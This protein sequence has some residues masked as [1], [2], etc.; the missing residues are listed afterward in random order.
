[1]SLELSLRVAD[2]AALDTPLLIV[3]VPVGDA[4]PD[5]LRAFDG[6]AGGT[7]AA[8]WAST[9]F[10]GKRDETLVCYPKGSVRR[11]LLVGIGDATKV[12]AAALRRAAMI[13]GK[14]ARTLGVERAALAIPATTVAADRAVQALAEGAAFGA[15]HYTELKMPADPPKPPVAAIELIATAADPGHDAGLARGRAIAAGQAFARGLQVLPAD[16]C[17]PIF[18]AERAKELAARHGMKLT[19]LDQ[20][21]LEKEGMHALLAVAK[22]SVNEPRFIALEY[23]GAEGA[24]V[25]L[26]GKGVTFDAGGISIKPAQGME[27]MKYDMSGAAGVLGTM[28][29]LGQLKP[30]LH[31]VGLVPSAENMVSGSAYRPGDVVRSHHGKTIEVLNTDAE[32][33]LLLADSLSWARRYNPAAVVDCATL[34]GA[35]VIG[36]GHTASAVMGTDPELVAQLIAAGQASGE[37][38]WELPLWDEYRDLIK[39]DIADVKN[40]GGR[41]AGSITAGWFLREFV[42]G[43]PWAH[44]DIAGTAYTDRESAMHGKGPMGVPV[45]LFSEFLLARL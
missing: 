20:A 5:S 17:T 19:V 13:G 15:W 11:L 24:P 26:V 45:R 12:D 2:P 8:A 43:Y 3:P 29:M 37:R 32:G 4:V 27:E 30:K 38:C 14:R 44:L 33:R 23:E 6:S 42:E 31:V 36:L 28:E 22:G 21:A 41:P 34:T 9:D 18:L 10:T 1:M 39:S 25:V 40:T 7:I 35:V 16:T